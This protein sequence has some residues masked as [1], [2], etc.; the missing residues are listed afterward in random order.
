MYVYV[1]RNV[2]QLLLVLRYATSFIAVYMY[3]YKFNKNQ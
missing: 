1:R 3:V 2:Q